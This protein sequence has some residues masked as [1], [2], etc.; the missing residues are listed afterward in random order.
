VFRVLYRGRAIPKIGL[1]VALVVSCALAAA[2]DVKSS[3]SAE[4]D[5][6]A[7]VK[8]ASS[9]QLLGK[10]LFQ[11]TLAL[12]SASHCVSRVA[13]VTPAKPAC[14]ANLVAQVAD[15]LRTPQ[16][17]EKYAVLIQRAFND[18][19]WKGP[20]GTQLQQNFDLIW[21]VSVMLYE[22]T[23]HSS[24]GRLYTCEPDGSEDGLRCRDE[25]QRVEVVP[26]PADVEILS[27]RHQPT[28]G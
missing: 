26:I 22:S 28:S 20:G 5:L 8:D 2:A 21:R 13:I 7:I 14:D 18:S 4:P 16:H 1:G 19:L 6:R 3:A 9:A 24:V 15:T 27:D 10:V 11:D 17:L 25:L 12:I 23:L